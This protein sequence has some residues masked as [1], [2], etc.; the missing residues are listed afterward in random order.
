M[1]KPEPI[2]QHLPFHFKEDVVSYL[3]FKSKCSLRMCSKDDQKVV[4]SRPITIDYFGL[5]LTERPVDDVHKNTPAEIVLRDKDVTMSKFFSP[6]SAIVYFMKIFKLDKKFKVNTL[7]IHVWNYN[8]HSNHFKFFKN[9]LEC[10]NTEKVRPKI[11]NFE[12]P[13]SFMDEKQLESLVRAVNI[14][15]LETMSLGCA[16]RF[17][18]ENLAR[19]EQWTKVKALKLHTRDQIDPRWVSHIQRLNIRVGKLSPG[20]ISSLLKDLLSNNVPH[21]SFISVSTYYPVVNTRNATLNNIFKKLISASVASVPSSA[22]GQI[23]YDALAAKIEMLRPNRYWKR[24]HNI[25]TRALN[26]FKNCYFSPI[27]CVLM[28][29]RRK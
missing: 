26:Q 4:D 28:E 14:E 12:L 8:L 29:R 1:S 11:R 23:D 17:Q 10:M 5:N 21:G 3:D 15:H 6:H 22:D 2:W 9:F 19:S 18:L 25:D 20:C 16:T 24:A 7:N 13:T 27:Q